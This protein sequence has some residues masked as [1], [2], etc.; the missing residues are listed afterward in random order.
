MSPRILAMYKT[1]IRQK[2]K[3][4]PKMAERVI[5]DLV[6]LVDQRRSGQATEMDTAKEILIQ[7]GLPEDLVEK[8]IEY[9]GTAHAMEIIAEAVAAKRVLC[10]AGIKP[11]LL[12]EAAERAS[13]LALK[14]ALQVLQ[15]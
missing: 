15:K 2:L 7:S 12:E 6:R 4:Q 10:E 8:A 9:P 1:A 5:S 11:E 14:L 13:P 3:Q